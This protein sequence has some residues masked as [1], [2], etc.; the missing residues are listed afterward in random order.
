MADVQFSKNMTQIFNDWCDFLQS[1]GA[2]LSENEIPEVLDFGQE[3]SSDLPWCAPLL[4]EGVLGFSGPDAATFLHGQL[5]NDIEHLD[6]EVRLAAYCTAKGRMLASLL[7][8]R[9][10]DVIYARLPREILPAIQKRL[11]MYVLRSKVK[12]ENLSDQI[13][14][15]GFSGASAAIAQ[16]WPDLD[17]QHNVQNTVM[18]GEHGMLLRLQDSSER[19]RHL[20]FTTPETVRLAWPEITTHTVPESYW[21]ISQLHCG[22]PQIVQATQEKF[23]PQMINFE[24]IG[25][26]NF[27]K[28]CYPGQEIVAR[29][30]Y[31]G[32][33]K[34]RMYLCS[35][36][37]EAA[38]P[39]MELF[40]SE[41]PEQPCG[42]VVNAERI[43]S[44]QYL[45]LVELK[46]HCLASGSIH[47][48]SAQ[49]AQLRVQTMP[50]EIAEPN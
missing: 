34:R 23:V 37:A 44:V 39:A 38:T 22:I 7:V 46:M 35:M 18:H 3:R 49:G 29:S 43:D 45:A 33:Q 28:G 2:K 14:Q 41:D 4:T 5:S 1:Q 42:M 10:D 48:G 30:Q 13:V 50:Y 15:I 20:W 40:W 17:S 11:Q 26:V 21:R 6:R 16:F 36:N 47:L 32:K 24:L 25:G 8:W 9:V 12:I 19:Q 27:K 31:L